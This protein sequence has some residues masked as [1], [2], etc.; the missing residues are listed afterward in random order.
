LR[1]KELEKVHDFGGV[2]EGACYG[3]QTMGVRA[4]VLRY[5]AGSKSGKPSF[6][7]DVYG[8]GCRPGGSDPGIEE[9]KYLP[10]EKIQ[11]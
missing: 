5:G 10:G 7:V 4:G 3:E 9:Y 11:W 8:A 2:Y 6:R 1:G